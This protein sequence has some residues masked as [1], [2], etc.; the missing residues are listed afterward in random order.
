M[1]HS[2]TYREMTTSDEWNVTRLFR[3][4]FLS[5]NIVNIC[6][7]KPYERCVDVMHVRQ[8]LG[9]PYCSSTPHRRCTRDK[10]SHKHEHRQ[11]SASDASAR[12]IYARM[13][14]WVANAT[15]SI[16]TTRCLASTGAFSRVSERLSN[17]HV[18]RPF[19]TTNFSL[20]SFFGLGLSEGKERNKRMKKKTQ[21]K[22]E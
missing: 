3:R 16:H 7:T 17:A 18:R 15:M 12:L 2:K 9:Q 19:R 11:H 4:Q 5:C 14:V 13:H 1:D 6:I 22:K 10:R 20:N 8:T 21:E